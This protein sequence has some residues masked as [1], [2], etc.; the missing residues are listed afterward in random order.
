[1]SDDPWDACTRVIARLETRLKSAPDRALFLRTARELV[2][3]L[4]AVSAVEMSCPDDPL[5]QPLCAVGDR[6]SRAA[7][8]RWDAPV[9]ETSALSIQLWLRAD[10]E[11]DATT[12]GAIDEALPAMG[13]LLVGAIA[14]I[15]LDEAEHELEA[16]SQLSARLFADDQ[17]E[18][19]W[20][21]IAVELGSSMRVDRLSLL[22]RRG[23]RFQLVGSSVQARFDPRA[24]QVRQ[25]QAVATSID[26]Q[27]GTA[28]HA[29]VTLR[30]EDGDAI[31]TFLQTGHSDE[32]LATRL[33]AGQV[34]VIGEVFDADDRPAADV[35]TVRRQLF[36]AAIGEVLRS[37][38]QGYFQRGRDWLSR[39]SNRWRI[40]AAAGLLAFL[41]L[42]P[43][44]IRVAADGRIVPRTQYTVHAPVTGQ[45]Q[46]M[47]CESGMQVSVGQVLCEFSSH[48]L[49]LQTT[50]LRGEWVAVQEQLQIAATRRGDD[51]S[52]DVASD[53]RV[54]EARLQGLEKQL[55][56][57][58]Q[59]QADLVVHSPIAGTVTLVT[60]DDVGQL[61]TPRPVHVGDSVIRVINQRDGY[62][63]ELDVPD[64]EIGYV[65]A[66]A[67]RQA[68]DPVACRFRIRSEPQR[69]R[70]GT[71]HGLDQVASLDRFGR[72]V[73]TASIR[74]DEQDATFAA[75]AGVVGW[76]DCN[77]SAA[78]FVLCRKVIE[79]LRL[80]GWL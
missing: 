51:S 34:L 23:Q 54:L 31:A 12:R 18:A 30:G 61:Q 80:W 11:S 17:S 50:R 32:L 9:T 41:C 60:P 78:G 48:D 74:P 49:D 66:A 69:Q 71:L 58:Q 59:R 42:Y 68:D 63:V 8:L 76:I 55:S 70:H 39:R 10:S 67:A 6:P 21:R 15:R 5:D 40:A 65:L 22:V 7:D 14:R 35:T 24:D 3:H 36:E 77:R 28:E 73:V 46:R 57:L 43:M 13:G 45:I 64:Q 75:D 53:R 1:M 27:F 33:G 16:V 47:A 56:L 52:K 2:D 72:L 79:Q 20:H 44:T 4:P 29:T 19:R 26:Q 25:T 62:R 37:H 38:H